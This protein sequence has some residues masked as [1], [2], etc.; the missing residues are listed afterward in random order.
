MRVQF[1][2]FTIFAFIAIRCSAA[3]GQENESHSIRLKTTEGK[4]YFSPDNWKT[5]KI[6]DKPSTFGKN[7]TSL[8]LPNNAP[9]NLL[10]QHSYEGISSNGDTSYSIPTSLVSLKNGGYFCASS[11]ANAK[12]RFTKV[13]ELGLPVWT[14]YKGDYTLPLYINTCYEKEDRISCNGWRLSSMMYPDG[15]Y[16]Y[17]LILSPDGTEH[18]SYFNYSELGWIKGNT[19]KGTAQISN[20]FVSLGSFDHNPHDTDHVK[21]NYVYVDPQG[22]KIVDSSYDLWNNHT[23]T[24]ERAI[25]DNDGST[26]FC[27]GRVYP[28][29]PKVFNTSDIILLKIDTLGNILWSKQHGGESELL[30]PREMLRV[31]DGYLII[32]QKNFLAPEG[33]GIFILKV[34][35]EG[36]RQWLKVHRTQN[37][38]S[39][40]AAAITGDGGCIIGGYV[41]DFTKT[42][43][44][45]W[46]NDM[47][48]LKVDANG[49]KLWDRTWG[50]QS[51]EDMITAVIEDKDRNIV[52][53]G[54]TG[55]TEDLIPANAR[56]YMAKLS[57]ASA[58]VSTPD[59]TTM[60]LKIY[61]NPTQHTLTVVLPE[62]S[63]D[64]Q[65]I[66]A[67]GIILD[68]FHT[69][70]RL[71]T[72]NVEQYPTGTYLLRSNHATATFIVK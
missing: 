24:S 65:V 60:E 59:Q 71:L 4:T 36:N 47:Y 2:K 41:G 37:N 31:S 15:G 56:M 28:Y 7:A 67:L 16:L 42:Q 19:T 3:F 54:Y 57:N 9:E 6:I 55:G 30:Q 44:L 13:N 63:R 1:K 68:K 26:L 46:T 48:L 25:A 32:G 27:V 52:I 14:H 8:S 18:N 50:Q 22:S 20:G 33:W 64:V 10:W 23:L 69:T 17:S 21:L 38:T 40:N 5:L 39:P 62:D 45:F 72:V 49:D 35:F 58:S 66:N 51:S 11:G 12:Y 43:S 29:E 61:P 34:D 53:A 70:E